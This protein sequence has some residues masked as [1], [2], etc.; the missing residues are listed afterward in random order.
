M[1]GAENWVTILY[2]A[3]VASQEK[4]IV[5]HLK[6]KIRQNEWCTTLILSP[7]KNLWEKKEEIFVAHH[8]VV[9]V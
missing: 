8:I 2:S 3:S 6:K 4:K 9:C 5:D 1:T 7:Q